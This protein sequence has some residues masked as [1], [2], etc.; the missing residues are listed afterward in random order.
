MH[1]GPSPGAPKGNQNALKQGRFTSEAIAE[2]RVLAALL[3][4]M[5]ELAELVDDE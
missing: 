5:K 4:D 2:R 3:H 1:G